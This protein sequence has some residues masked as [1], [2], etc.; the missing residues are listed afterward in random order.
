[1]MCSTS[2]RSYLESQEVCH[3]ERSEGPYHGYNTLARGRPVVI[4]S[5]APLR[6]TNVQINR[7]SKQLQLFPYQSRP[8]SASSSRAARSTRACCGPTPSSTPAA[9]YGPPV[10]YCHLLRPCPRWQLEWLINRTPRL[11][12]RRYNSGASGGGSLL[13]VPVFC[14]IR[15]GS[16]QICWKISM[17]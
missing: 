12:Q 2:Q 4:R 8:R 14:T 11:Q 7:L 16:E 17:G 13:A 6:M 1:M 9:N 15:L 3:P 5:F 10:I